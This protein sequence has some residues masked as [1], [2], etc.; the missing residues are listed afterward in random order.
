MTCSELSPVSV[1]DVASS[2]ST[3]SDASSS[4]STFATVETNCSSDNLINRT[5]CAARPFCEISCTSI[6]II[7]PEFVTTIKS[8]SPV[9]VVIHT[10]LPFFSVIVAVLIPLPPRLDKR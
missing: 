8:S 7:T 6:R 5:P 3:A 4:S 2:V 1:A 9:T 10:M